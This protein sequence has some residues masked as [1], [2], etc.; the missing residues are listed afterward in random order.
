MYLHDQTPRVRR[1][2]PDES[3]RQIAPSGRFNQHI[4]QSLRPDSIRNRSGKAGLTANALRNPMRRGRRTTVA[5]RAES[6]GIPGGKGR[7]GLMPTAGRRPVPALEEPLRPWSFV[8]LREVP[9]GQRCLRPWKDVGLQWVYFPPVNSSQALAS[10]RSSRP[11]QRIQDTTASRLSPG[12]EGKAAIRAA[13]SRAS[14]PGSGA[15]VCRRRPAP[16]HVRTTLRCRSEGHGR[17][18]RAGYLGGGCRTGRRPGIAPDRDWPI[19]VVW[20]YTK[21]EHDGRRCRFGSSDAPHR[22]APLARRNGL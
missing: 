10:H 4:N 22:D 19:L 7:F 2:S 21:L 11:S 1:D 20:L 17:K 14:G 5:D 18:R 3:T 15:G 8:A 13:R 9:R 6:P 16:P 12:R